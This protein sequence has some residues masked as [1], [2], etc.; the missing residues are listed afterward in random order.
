MDNNERLA[1][2]IAEKLVQQGLL[3]N[4][5]DTVFKRKL[6]KGELKDHDWKFLLESSLEASIGN[7]QDEIA[8]NVETD[9][10]E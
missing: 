10:A 7:T 2:I 6:A 4:A 1:G 9:E 5:D 3:K 8:N